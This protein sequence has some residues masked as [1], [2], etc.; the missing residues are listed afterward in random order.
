MKVIGGILTLLVFVSGSWAL[1]SSDSWTRGATRCPV[2]D[3]RA[4]P[5]YTYGV[6]Y[7]LPAEAD[8]KD[9]ALMELDFNTELLYFRDILLGDLDLRF[10]FRSVVPLNNSG[11]ELPDQLLAVSL[12]TRWTWRYVND[13]ALQLRIEPGF[14]TEMQ[15]WSTES[16]AMPV[17]FKGIKT[18]SPELSAVAGLSLRLRFDRPVMPAAGVVWQPLDYFRLEATV[19]SG[20][21]IYYPAPDWA[22]RLFWDWESMT[23]Q[24]P[25]DDLNR[26]RLTMEASRAGIGVSK[27]LSPEFLIGADL[28]MLGGRTLEFQRN[29]GE[30][31]VGWAPYLRISAG[32]AF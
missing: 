10:D 32:G 14:Y 4:D 19:P 17:S 28:G 6:G 30:H 11:M 22:C 20:R 16:L 31:T 3:I 13:T 24:L 15:S 29:G 1:P 9:L 5:A 18:I 8:G 21:A 23:Y 25:D 26:D 27:A 7:V 2:Q 12:D